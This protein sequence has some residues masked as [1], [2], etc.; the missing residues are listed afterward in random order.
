M[1]WRGPY[2]GHEGQHVQA[3]SHHQGGG[4]EE[5]DCEDEPHSGHPVHGLLA[6][7]PCLLHTC[8]LFTRYVSGYCNIFLLYTNI[9]EFFLLLFLFLKFSL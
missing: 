6:A 7:V 3:A 1:G 9:F 2:A 5:E 8:L 4:E